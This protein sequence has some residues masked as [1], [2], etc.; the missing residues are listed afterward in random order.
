MSNAVSKELG[1]KPIGKLIIKQSFPAAIGILVMSLNMLVDTIFVGNWV[2]SNAI[3]AITIVL[4]ITFLIASF[5]MAIGIGGSSI[6]SRAFGANNDDKANHVF[7]NQ[8]LISIS[9][10]LILVI[11]GFLFKDQALLLFGAKGGIIQPASDYFSIVLI[12]IPFLAL[13]MTGNPV[14]R[15]EGMPIY[16]MVAMLIPSI[17]NIVLDYVF[18]V[19]M[20]L[21]IIGA[22]WATTIS[23][24]MSFIFIVWF[25][26]SKHSELKIKLKWLRFEWEYIKEIGALGGVT[27]ARQGVISILSIILNHLL[28]KYGGGVSIA[29][30]GII[31]RVL[32]FALFPVMGIAQGFMPI[33]GYNYGANKFPRVRETIKK[34]MLYASILALIVFIFI[35]IFPK[36]LVNVFTSDLAIL[37]QTPNALRT[38]FLVTPLIAIQLIGSAYFQ[39]VGKAKMALLLTLTKQG[40]FL[41]PLILILPQFYG[42]AGIWISFPIADFCATALTAYF[43]RKEMNQFK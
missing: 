42:L 6:I 21:G 2:G 1:E 12:G 32:M 23:Y 29:V 39:A 18:I 35:M 26:L 4:P 28:Y 8:I 9:V 7:G 31:S 11:F 5:G 22:G 43:L 30:Y 20:D 16:S 34:S 15:A 13:S 19:Q 24:A 33:L 41:I 17:A 37:E 3:A 14:I 38:V 27:L 10:A 36:E 25:F 40:F